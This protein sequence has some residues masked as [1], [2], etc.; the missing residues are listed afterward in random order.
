MSPSKKAHIKNEILK[1]VHSLHELSSSGHL[2]KTAVSKATTKLMTL[3]YKYDTSIYPPLP[4]HH[5]WSINSD[6]SLSLLRRHCY[7]K[8]GSGMFISHFALTTKIR[9]HPQSRQTLS[10]TPSLNI[11]KT[12]EIQFTINMLYVLFGL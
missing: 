4:E 7:G 10:S 11:F 8:L 6:T 3:G 5:D 9:N 1:L 2:D 12:A